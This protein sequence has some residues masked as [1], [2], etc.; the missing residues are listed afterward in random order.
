MDIVAE[1]RGLGA[2]E[3]TEPRETKRKVRLA[4]L[5][6]LVPYVARYRWHVIAAF[7]SL[8][9]A[10]AATLAVPIA[11]RRMIDSASRPIESD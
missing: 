8:L 6:S 3:G 7:L 9:V 2:I 5:L 4:P 10:A 11:V 1:G